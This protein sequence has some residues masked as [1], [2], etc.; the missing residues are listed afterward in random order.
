M[1]VDSARKITIRMFM[2]LAYICLDGYTSHAGGFIWLDIHPIY[3][4]LG[5]E[6]NVH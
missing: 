4:A 1:L 6:Y 3:W 2:P 5:K